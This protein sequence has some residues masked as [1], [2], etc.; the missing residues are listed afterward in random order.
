M[1]TAHIYFASRLADCFSR[2]LN[3][4]G[5]PNFRFVPFLYDPPTFAVDRVP[6]AHSNA[7]S[8]HLIS[9]S[10]LAGVRVT[11]V[12]VNIVPLAVNARCDLQCCSQEQAR[13]KV[14]AWLRRGV[15]VVLRQANGG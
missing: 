14:E 8:R 11:S 2:A 4:F 9:A 12:H 7:L 13:S 3:E 5:L 10:A 1:P 6:V 15:G